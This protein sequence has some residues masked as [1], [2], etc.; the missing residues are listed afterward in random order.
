MFL[1][2]DKLTRE[3]KSLFASNLELKCAI[4]YWGKHAI[5]LLKI[6]TDSPNL[7]IICCLK[8][9]KS[10]PKLIRKFGPRARQLDNLHSK[11]IWTPKRAIVSSA[12]ASSNGLPIDDINRRTM[13]GL[14]EAGVL[15]EDKDSLAQINQWFDTKYDEAAAITEADLRQAEID[16]RTGFQAKACELIDLS[17]EDMKTRRFCVLLY[18]GECTDQQDKE[19]AEIDPYT[20]AL[21]DISWFVDHRNHYKRYP[22]GKIA[23]TFSTSP[24]RKRKPIYKCAYHFNEQTKWPRLS[25]GG[26]VVFCTKV[27]PGDGVQM[28]NIKIGPKTI[29]A[30]KEILSK[31]KQILKYD[32]DDKKGQGFS[33]WQDL[34]EL[35]A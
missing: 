25:D 21:K 15:I 13:R 3:I 34:H 29:N 35:M 24:S 16:R 32:L 33:S 2:E 12:N 7:K 28:P 6:N 8:G 9:G 11:V 1:A 5:D 17:L 10:D 31:R 18:N 26:Y 30:L 23:L 14:I 4:S 20:S 22:S 19:V 27:R